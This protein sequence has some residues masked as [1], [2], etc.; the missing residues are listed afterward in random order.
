MKSP[1]RLALWNS[2]SMPQAELHEAFYGGGGSM[3]QA[4]F[5]GDGQT[6]CSVKSISRLLMAFTKMA[7]M[8]TL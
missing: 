7:S 8:P 2:G 5:Y 6:N 3:P 4:L 1:L